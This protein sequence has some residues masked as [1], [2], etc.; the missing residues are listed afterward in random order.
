ALSQAWWHMA[1][2]RFLVALGVG[3][4]WA[5]A[6]ALVAE[7]F[8]APARA[9]SLAI[10]HGSSVFGTLL[11]VAAGTVLVANPA[12]GWRWGLVVGAA[13][14]LLIVWVRLALREPERRQGAPTSSLD[15]FRGPLLRHTLVGVGLATVG[16]ATFWGTHIYG[17]NVLLHAAGA[18]GE[19]GPAL[20]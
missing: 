2:F 13:R 14:A 4:E 19:T 1:V 16:L 18:T 5:V 7:V 15:L 10:F 11:A 9:W 8:P 12:L 6:A 3:G 17:K 20:K